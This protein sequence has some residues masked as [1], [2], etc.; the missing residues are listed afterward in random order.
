[1]PPIYTDNSI[2]M[3]LHEFK[4]NISKYMREL[5]TGD[6]GLIILT[7]N[8]KPIGGVFS[9]AGSAINQKRVR[10][11]GKVDPLREVMQKLSSTKLLF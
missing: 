1:M 10:D 7:R 8:G 3:G 6:K 5:D 4:G 2:R 9:F 11:G